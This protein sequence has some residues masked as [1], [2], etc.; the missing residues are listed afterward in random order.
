M[1]AKII[2]PRVS[3]VLKIGNVS[4]LLKIGILFAD[5]RAVTRVFPM[6]VGNA[7]YTCARYSLSCP[8]IVHVGQTRI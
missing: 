3:N 6:R 1:S 5:G 8:G 4:N 2:I 7:R